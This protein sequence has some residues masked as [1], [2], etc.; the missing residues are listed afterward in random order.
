MPRDLITL[1][2]HARAMSGRS[3]SPDAERA[4][5]KAIADEIDTYLGAD[6]EG[7]GLFGEVSS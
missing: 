4:L 6:D 2:D 3:S 1:R 7:P 5:W